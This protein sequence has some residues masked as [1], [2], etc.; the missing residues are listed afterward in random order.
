MRRKK[1]D[2]LAGGKW[3]KP[4][5]NYVSRHMA[6]EGGRELNSLGG[7]PRNPS[8]SCGEVKLGASAQVFDGAR[9]VETTTTRRQ[10]K[11]LFS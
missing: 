7:E 9:R 3:G 4:D 11:S 8:G 6:G 5:N 1:P 2:D 10:A